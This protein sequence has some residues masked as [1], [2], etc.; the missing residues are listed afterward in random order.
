MDCLQLAVANK[1]GDTRCVLPLTQKKIMSFIKR[2]SDMLGI[3]AEREKLNKTVSDIK[4]RLNEL[5]AR[6]ANA[7]TNPFVFEL[8][9]D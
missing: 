8:N 5:E 3:P 6:P 1:R 4:T 9:N 2:L 7:K